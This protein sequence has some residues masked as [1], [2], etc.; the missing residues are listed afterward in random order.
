MNPAIVLHKPEDLGPLYEELAPGIVFYASKMLDSM[1]ES[2]AICMDAFKAALEKKD[3]ESLSRLR[4]YLYTHV[5]HGCFDY[6]K[7]K[8]FHAEEDIQRR[9]IRAEV[10]KKIFDEIEALPKMP[11]LVLEMVLKGQQAEEIAGTLGITTDYVY[12]HK[13]RAVRALKLTG[14]QNI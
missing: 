12:M 2:E 9:I 3:F 6:L 14:L 13:L 5:R 10:M 4:E 7:K 11:R 1:E 8:A